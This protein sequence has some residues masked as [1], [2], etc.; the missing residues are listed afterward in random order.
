[1]AAS[2]KVNANI[3]SKTTVMAR[4][5]RSPEQREEEVT[6]QSYYL[7]KN[8]EISPFTRT[9]KVENFQISYLYKIGIS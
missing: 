5:S 7:S 3:K 2:S 8:Y 9:D 1:L 4:V 6:W